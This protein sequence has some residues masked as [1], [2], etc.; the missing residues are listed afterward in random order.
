MRTGAKVNSNG[1]LSVASVKHALLLH[2]DLLEQ[3]GFDITA[4]LPVVDR[5]E[6]LYDNIRAGNAGFTG[7]VVLPETTDALPDVR[8]PLASLCVP[9]LWAPST[10]ST[11]IYCSA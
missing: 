2:Y 5:F 10:S 7:G 4:P 6:A 3:C 1:T 9:T 11:A 8:S